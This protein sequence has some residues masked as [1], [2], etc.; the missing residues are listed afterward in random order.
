MKKLIKILLFKES[1][2]VIAFYRKTVYPY[3]TACPFEYY[4]YYE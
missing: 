1:F 2:E 4:E 3:E